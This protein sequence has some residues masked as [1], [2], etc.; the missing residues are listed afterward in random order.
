MG[1]KRTSNDVDLV[2]PDQY[3]VPKNK[4][5]KI[6]PPEPWPLLEFNPLPI[7]LPLA[8]RA[9][10]LPP[11]ID[12]TDPLALF[13]LIGTNNLLKELAAYTN[14]YTRLYPY[15][16]YKDKERRVWRSYKWKPTATRELLT[17]LAV[18]IYIGPLLE[19][20]IVNY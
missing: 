1:H 4:K 14:K 10:N 17:Y 20:D 18:T 3:I 15:Q 5:A 7:D 12:P 19:L 2:Q 16:E 13:K 11:H 8:D 9:L 6:P